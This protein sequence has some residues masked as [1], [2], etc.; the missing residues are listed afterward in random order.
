[1][2]AISAAKAPTRESDK[3]DLAGDAVELRLLFRLAR[4]DL[5]GGVGLLRARGK[6]HRGDKQR[7]A[8]RRDSGPAVAR[9]DHRSWFMEYS[10]P[11]LRSGSLTNHQP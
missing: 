7:R 3:R 2:P 10:P 6:R 5:A 9:M 8:E 11:S 4:L 1:M